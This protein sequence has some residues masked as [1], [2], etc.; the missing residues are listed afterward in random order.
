MHGKFQPWQ[1]LPVWALLRPGRQ[2][3][4]CPVKDRNLC[5]Q[6]LPQTWFPDTAPHRWPCW[7]TPQP[8]HSLRSSADIRL[9]GM[10]PPCLSVPLQIPDQPARPERPCGKMSSME[11]RQMSHQGNHLRGSEVS[12]YVTKQPGMLRAQPSVNGH[13]TQHRKIK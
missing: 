12:G 11:P 9:V 8:S 2:P 6:A 13:G 4:P 3:H 1:R 10:P 7:A 5:L